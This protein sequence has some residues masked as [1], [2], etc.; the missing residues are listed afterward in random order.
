MRNDI[1][2]ADIGT[3]IGPTVN[4]MTMT[5][6]STTGEERKSGGTVG[7]GVDRARHRQTENIISVTIGHTAQ[8]DLP[9]W[10]P[11]SVMDIIALHRE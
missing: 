1:T 4:A 8:L 5:C 9:R 3:T 11:L 7:H 10:Q 2:N 6:M